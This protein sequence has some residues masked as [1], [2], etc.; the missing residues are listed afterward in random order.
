M[1][2]GLAKLFRRWYHVIKHL[3][4]L[5]LDHEPFLFAIAGLSLMCS[6]LILLCCIVEIVVFVLAR[7]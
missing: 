7:H 5:Q 4:Q 2:K 3:D 6:G 1:I